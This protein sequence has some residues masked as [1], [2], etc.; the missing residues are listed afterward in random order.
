[1]EFVEAARSLGS[2]DTRILVYH[3]LPNI[4]APILVQVSLALSWATLTEA[5]L[6]F[7][8]LGT[9]PPTPSWGAMLAESRTLMELAPWTA[10]FPGLA[11]MIGVLGFNLVGDGLRDALDPRLRTQ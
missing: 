2:R 9:T 6:S 5:G 1:M 3:V 10:V 8:G 4:T 7:L 11:I